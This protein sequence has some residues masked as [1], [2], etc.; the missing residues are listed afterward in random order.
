MSLLRTIDR[1][2]GH[3]AI[4]QVPAA[5]LTVQRRRVSVST[6]WRL[7]IVALVVGMLA[8]AAFFPAMGNGFLFDDDELILRNPFVTGGLSAENVRWAFSSFHGGNW[9]PLTWLSHQLD[10][11]TW[12]LNPAGH[13]LTSVLL[14]AGNVALLFAVM[15]VLTGSV[16][17]SALLAV[18]FGVH[19]LRVESVVWVSERKDV[20]SMSFFLFGVGAW[21]RYAASPGH[22]RL[23]VVTALFACGLMAKPMLVTFPFVLLLLDWWPLGRWQGLRGRYGAAGAAGRLLGEKTPLFAL[24][25]A[26]SVLALIAQRHAGAMA[27]LQG[28]MLGARLGNA[29]VSSVS[30]LGKTVW[31]VDLS[32][33]YQHA[34]RLVPVW[35]WA[36]AL[37]LVVVITAAAVRAA[38]RQ[39]WFATGWLWFLG[40]LVPVIGVVQ[41]G[42]QALADR[43]TYLPAVGLSLALVWGGVEALRRWPTARPFLVVGSAAVVAT[44]S[45]ATWLQSGVWRDGVTL[46]THA[47]RVEPDNWLAHNNLGKYL[48]ERQRWTEAMGEILAALRL[49]PGNGMA[50]YNLAVILA[51]AGRDQEAI[52]EYR[53]TLQLEPAFFEALLEIGRLLNTA[54]KPAEAEPNLAEAVRLKPG[55]AHARFELGRA[56]HARGRVEEALQQY[57]EA[58]RLEPL[59]S[60]A[61][62][63]IGRALSSLGRQQ[64]AL[65]WLDLATQMRPDDA[66][67][68]CDRALALERLG[69]Y[70]DAEYSLRRAIGLSPDN[71][72]A[73]AAIFRISGRLRH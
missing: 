56:V 19:P 11:T 28:V 61:V 42:V 17:A 33:L 10:V 35:Q 51:Q 15:R 45:V 68:H 7:S 5:A 72:T 41:V 73:L 40:T 69:R 66:V 43:Y 9:I 22:G 70:A 8:A 44:L 4:G 64:E 37:A 49:N 21:R 13:H 14:H 29:L 39:P 67:A 2:S 32:P 27:P 36:G 58:Q 24:A 30:Y 59:L 62:V 12:G 50:H 18:L 20:L 53:E 25:G 26:A 65:P 34:G 23:A 54:G 55:D 71:A 48:I 16:W 52:A 63:N 6:M 60:E 47:V 3:G 57:S 31:P 46:F 1:D 38:R